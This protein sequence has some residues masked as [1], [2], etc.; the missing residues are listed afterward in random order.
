[1]TQ[2]KSGAG[3]LRA[4]FSAGNGGAVDAVVKPPVEEEGN[5][6]TDY[7][8]FDAWIY[9][10]WDFC[11]IFQSYLEEVSW[12]KSLLENTYNPAAWTTSYTVRTPDVS[13]GIT[14]S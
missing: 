9:W 3:N 11:G 2:P 12:L 4:D 6:N 8:F 5:P 1:V 7:Y 13:G 10:W 14:F